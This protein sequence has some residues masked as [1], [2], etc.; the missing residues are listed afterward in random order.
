MGL[1]PAGSGANGQTY[2]LPLRFEGRHLKVRPPYR[3]CF[4]ATLLF[5]S[6]DDHEQ[7]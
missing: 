3:L 1:A 5:S 6:G 7:A 2:P 4:G